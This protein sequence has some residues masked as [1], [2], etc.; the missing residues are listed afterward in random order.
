MII[1]NKYILT[2]K[3]EAIFKSQWTLNDYLLFPIQREFKNL[4]FYII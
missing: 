2:Y 4:S 3:F 1:V